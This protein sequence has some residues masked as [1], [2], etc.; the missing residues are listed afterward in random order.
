MSQTAFTDTLILRSLYTMICSVK[1]WTLRRRLP[2]VMMVPSPLSKHVPTPSALPVHVTMMRRQHRQFLLSPPCNR[3]NHL[4]L[5]QPVLPVFPLPPFL[6]GC[7]ADARRPRP[8]KDQPDLRV[9]CHPDTLVLFRV[10]FLPRY[11]RKYLPRLHR[12]YRV[13]F[14]AQFQAVALAAG[15]AAFPARLH[16]ANRVRFRPRSPALLRP[17]DQ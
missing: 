16:R 12:S 7:Q 13:L 6:L 17:K 5:A 1:P 15:Q 2:R 4:A 10:A 9:D 14:R 3:R 8:A 11:L